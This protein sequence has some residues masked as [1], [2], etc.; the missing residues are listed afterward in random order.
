M[1]PAGGSSTIENA[2]D[3]LIV[4]DVMV[5][6]ALP[7]LAMTTFFCRAATLPNNIGPAVTA[8]LLKGL[9]LTSGEACWAE[10]KGARAQVRKTQ[11]QN[12]AMYRRIIAPHNDDASLSERSSKP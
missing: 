10:A 5:S 8:S 4:I 2:G 6:G 11:A 3:G 7:V 1:V 9:G 12:A